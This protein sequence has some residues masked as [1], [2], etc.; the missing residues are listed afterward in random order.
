MSQKVQ[1]YQAQY[2]KFKR[3]RVRRLHKAARHPFAVPVLT[4]VALFVVTAGLF[5]I[6][7]RQPDHNNPNVVVISHDGKKQIVSSKEPTVGALLAKLSIAVNDGDVVEPALATAIQ[8]D[9][10]RV[11]IYRATP[12]EI[13]DGGHRTF[14]LSAGAT[15]RTVAAQAGLTVYPEDR[16]TEQPVTDFVGTGGISQVVTIDRATPI[17]VNLYGTPVVMRTHADTVGGLLAERNI[18][19]KPQDQVKPAAATPI[20]SA[21]VITVVRNGLSTITVQQDIPMPIQTVPDNSLAYGTSAVRQKGAPGKQ[22]VTYQV[23]TQNG[24]EV[25]RTAIQTTIVQQPVTQVVV[26]GSNLSGI[27]GDMALAGIDPSEYQYAD[28]IIS[29][30]S[31]WC[32]TKWQGEYGGC[33]AYHGTPSSSYTGYGLCQATPG[34][35]MASAGADWATNPVTQLRWCSGYARS[36]YGSW[37]AAYN[38]WLSHHNW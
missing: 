10:F 20:A 21:G 16:L 31:G 13:V 29:R 2:R 36:R 30:E 32:P 15:E 7:N 5:L 25:S 8:Q 18:K 28:Y 14:S 37:Q 33:Q 6:L 35:K 27:K 3:H 34:G 38:Y 4:F 19:L 23:N 22:A 24:V 26:L 17:N 9:D 12:V 1:R 11:N